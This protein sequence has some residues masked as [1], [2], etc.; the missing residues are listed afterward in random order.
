MK[1]E[2]EI[3][4]H[5]WWKTIYR[6]KDM[7]EA[8]KNKL[9]IAIYEEFEKLDCE[10]LALNGDGQ[11]VHCLV[12]MNP[13]LPIASVIRTVK[14]KSAITM[15]AHKIVRS[16]FKWSKG[17]IASSIAFTNTQFVQ[18]FIEKHGYYRA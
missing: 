18:E 2:V 16:H 3:W 12:K 10:C 9:Y 8:R 17:Y 14:S 6:R 1:F 5:I 15:N 4:V 13:Q 7:N 11:H